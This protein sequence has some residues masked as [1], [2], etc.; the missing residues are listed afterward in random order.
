MPIPSVLRLR[1]TVPAVTL[2]AAAAL[3]VGAAPSAFA[4][5]PA[6]APASVRA[7]ANTCPTWTVTG[8]GVNLRSGAGTGYRAIGSL[9]RGDSGTKVASSGS[10][11]KIK[12]DHKSKSGLKTGT[13][14]WVS[15]TYLEQCVYMHLD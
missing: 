9:Y 2:A 1:R 6:S 13:S 4:A 14:G 10:W 8:N 12:L 5:S 11:V 7:A 3:A 15:K